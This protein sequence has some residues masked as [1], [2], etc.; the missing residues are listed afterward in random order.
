MSSQAPII[1]ISIIVPVFNHWSLVPG[2][3]AALEA[4]SVPAGQFELLLVDNGS[5]S[6]P[7]ISGWPSFTRLLHCEQPGSYA[8]RNVGIGEAQG[9][10]LVFTDAD[11]RPEPDWLEKLLACQ[12]AE[13]DR[14]EVIVA[15]AIRV[16][17]EGEATAAALYDMAMGLP[18]ADYVKRGYGVTAN[19]AVPRGLMARMGGFDQRRFSGGDAAF[20]RLAVSCGARLVYG[21]QACVRH[22]ARQSMSELTTK[23]RRLKGGQLRNG[24]WHRRLLYGIRGFLPPL[25]AWRRVLGL[26]GFSARE[27]FVVA[28]VQGRLW[29]TEMVETLRLMLGGTPERR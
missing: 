21:E 28:G 16:V 22:P 7:E 17:T 10:L 13:D 6:L 5:D 18:V 11:C 1:R 24:P 14:D 12:A 15:G 27:R 2:L 29:L 25:R 4:Q 20:C 3:I 8:A 9:E 23:M 19:L 26:S